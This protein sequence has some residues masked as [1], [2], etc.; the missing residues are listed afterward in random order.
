MATSEAFLFLEDGTLIHGKSCGARGTSVGELV[1]NTSMSGYQEILTDPSYYG[2]IITM[3]FPHIGNYGT[4]P[5]DDESDKVWAKGLVVKDMCEKPRLRATLSLPSYLANNNT[6]AISGIDTRKLT[7]KLRSQGSLKAVIT[8]EST[9]SKNLFKILEKEPPML[10]RNLS[11]DVSCKKHYRIEN[12]QAQWRIVAIDFGIKKS[13]LKYL[14]ERGCEIHVVPAWSTAEEILSLHPQA[15]FL[16]NGPGDPAAVTTAI[17][18]IRNL[19]GTMPIFGI[20]LGHQ[21]LCLALG[22]TTYKLKF[23]HRGANH[24][25]L[26]PAKNSVEITTHNHGFAVNHP[27]ASKSEGSHEV[28]IQNLNDHT[29]E[30]IYD[31][32]NFLLSIQYHPES[33][34]GPLDSLY[35]FDK[36]VEMM[37]GFHK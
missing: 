29:L 30:G 22:A 36:F 7:R 31:P 16:S 24:P 17:E 35:L 8:T 37:R 20:C 25:V 18:T 10:G 15:L 32:K 2:Q 4:S 9:N 5:L 13:I 27:G 19:V 26:N 14:K 21:L 12:K 33:S 11:F 28:S 34:P 1:F 3:T 6:V 23:G